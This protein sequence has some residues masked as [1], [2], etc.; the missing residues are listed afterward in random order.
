MTL[1]EIKVGD[2]QFNILA[3]GDVLAMDL[4]EGAWIEHQKMVDNAP[5]W[6]K[7]C[8]HMQTAFKTNL[9]CGTVFRRTV[10]TPPVLIYDD[11][12]RE[13]CIDVATI[14]HRHGFNTHVGRMGDGNVAQELNEYATMWWKDLDDS[15]APPLA[16]VPFDKRYEIYFRHS[17]PRPGEYL[18]VNETVKI[19]RA[20]LTT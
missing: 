8:L 19:Q 14:A 4:F 2:Y 1:Y 13:E 9:T 20:K 15:H 5:P 11:P 7:A 6:E 17:G 16:D 12:A 3:T 18:E 10:D